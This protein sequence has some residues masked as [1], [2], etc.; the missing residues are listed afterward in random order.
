M[1][2][3]FIIDFLAYGWSIAAEDATSRMQPVHCDDMP[4]TW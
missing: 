2:G 1:G 4:E 3:N